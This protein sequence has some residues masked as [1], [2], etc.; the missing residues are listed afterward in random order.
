[1]GCC[2]SHDKVTTVEVILD[3][4]GVATRVP[5][6][7]GTHLIKT[8]PD[9]ETRMEKKP[10]MKPSDTSHLSKPMPTYSPKFPISPFSKKIHPFQ[11][12]EDEKN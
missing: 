7:K 2:I 12:Q 1:M 11:E 9:K 8:Y 5:D 4:H 10:L 3:S 6:G